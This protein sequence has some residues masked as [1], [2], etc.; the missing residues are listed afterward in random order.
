MVVELLVFFFLKKF[1][2]LASCQLKRENFV[3]N[4]IELMKMREAKC[5]NRVGKNADAT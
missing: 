2:N 3:D 5:R 4:T 1:E